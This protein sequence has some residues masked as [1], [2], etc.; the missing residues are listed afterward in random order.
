MRK[1]GNK[2]VSIKGLPT[3]NQKAP[4]RINLSNVMKTVLQ[5]A[6]PAPDQSCLGTMFPDSEGEE[7]YQYDPICGSVLYVSFTGNVVRVVARSSFRSV[8]ELTNGDESCHVVLIGHKFELK[9]EILYHAV[10]LFGRSTDGHC[11]I[12]C[13]VVETVEDQPGEPNFI[14]CNPR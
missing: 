9:M 11:S 7:I 6:V 1:K 8:Y 4:I 2:A 5:S 13:E 14:V 3:Q 10:G 12:L